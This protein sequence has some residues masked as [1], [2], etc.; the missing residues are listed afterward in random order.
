MLRC[1]RIEPALRDR[2]WTVPARPDERRWSGLLILSGAARV[3]NSENLIWLDP[4]MVFL[5]PS[6]KTWTLRIL[7]GSEA[8]LFGF[9]QRHAT[10]AI[11]HG[12]DGETLVQLLEDPIAVRLVE[13]RIARK[14][15]EFALSLVVGQSL[16]YEAGQETLFD[17]ALKIVLVAL[18]RNLPESFSATR[19]V[20]RSSQLLHRFRH[21]LETRF[22]ERWN[23]AQYAGELKIGP[24]RLHDLCT[25]KLG[26]TPS[27]LIRERSNYEA[28]ILL[29]NSSARVS[30]IS[31]RLGF[32][33]PSHFSRF[34]LKV[35]GESPRAFRLRADAVTQSGAQAIIDFADW[36]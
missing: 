11:G 6:D 19:H 24:D 5:A 35:N 31:E 4:S 20:D 25:A 34:F 26:K 3:E 8:I 27:E 18:L 28:K 14:E 22:R 15:L 9:D 16:Q 29:R 1:D 10:S 12:A 21:L 36:P 17:A 23:V 2:V 32:S 30:E 13:G 33:D 7:A